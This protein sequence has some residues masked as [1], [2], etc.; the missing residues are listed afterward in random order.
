MI[1]K[2]KSV[3]LREVWIHEAYD[4]TEWL[5]DNIDILNDVLRYADNKASIRINWCAVLSYRVQ[6]SDIEKVLAKL[7]ELYDLFNKIS[8]LHAVLDRSK[9]RRFGVSHRF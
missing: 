7:D 5:K 9:E 3:P 8:Y 4:F 6:R 2:I 1:G